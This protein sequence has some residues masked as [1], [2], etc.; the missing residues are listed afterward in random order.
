MQNELEFKK[1]SDYVDKLE[2]KITEESGRQD[3][4]TSAIQDLIRV[5][6]KLTK[7]NSLHEDLDGILEYIKANC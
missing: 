3:F 2:D 4:T 7:D 1:L 6:K 5:V